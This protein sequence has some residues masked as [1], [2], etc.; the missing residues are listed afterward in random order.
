[1]GTKENHDRAERRECAPRRSRAAITRRE[2]M[3][4]GVMSPTGRARR[5]TGSRLPWFLVAST[6][7]TGTRTR[8]SDVGIALAGPVLAALEPSRGAWLPHRADLVRPDGQDEEVQV[9]FVK[10]GMKLLAASFANLIVLDK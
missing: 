4:G 1:M 6:R 8:E 7:C 3:I 10:Y 5:L 9:R 2:L